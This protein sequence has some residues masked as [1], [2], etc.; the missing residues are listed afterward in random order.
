MTKLSRW[1]GILEVTH[2]SYQDDTP[3][4]Y[5]SDDPFV[6]RFKVKPIIWLDKDETIPIKDDRV[7]NRL[8]FTKNHKK[9]STTWTG[10]VRGSLNR[11]DDND[12]EILEKLLTDQSQHHEKFPLD[13]REYEKLVTHRVRRLDKTVSVSVPQDSDDD[14]EEPSDT[15]IEIRESL[16]I[17]DLLARIGT[18]MGLHIWIPKHDRTALLSRGDGQ[19]YPLLETLPLNYDETTLKTIEQIDV[20]WLRGRS[21]VRAFEVE[22]TTSIYSGILRMA[23]L[24]ALQPNMDI[25]LHIIAPH[26]RRDKVFREL[27]RPVFSLLDSGPLSETCT[28]ISYDSIREISALKHLT[29]LSD[30]VL[31][32]Y[33]EEAE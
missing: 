21:I 20:L 10:K 25:N 26:S 15:K 22:H 33:S 3:I 14:E 18:E 9:N 2:E 24:L 5:E 19:E 4:F 6:I 16:Q 8:S 12:A 32:Q 23:D 31:E 13:A 29:Y 27:L 1:I 30:S 11:L 17:Q 28:Y 7:W